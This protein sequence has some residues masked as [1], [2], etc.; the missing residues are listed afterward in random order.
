MEIKE[1]KFVVYTALFGDYDELVDPKEKYEGCDFICFTDQKHL[2][3]NI[4]K[5]KIVES[6]ILPPNLM[7]RMYK[8]LPHKYLSNYESSLYIDANVI[9]LDNPLKV[10]ER[11]KEWLIVVPRH[12]DRNCIYDEAIACIECNKT[13]IKDTLEQVRF[14]KKAG[15][16]THYGLSENNIIFRMHNH[17]KVVMLMEDVWKEL[18]RWKTY[19][20]QLCFSYVIWKNNFADIIFMEYNARDRVFFDMKPH[21]RKGSLFRRLKRK[22]NHM[23][24]VL[25]DKNVYII[26]DRLNI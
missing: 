10:L 14:Y 4:W 6:N 7:N 13:K 9:L 15:F 2:S 3:S 17:P 25:I 11:Y 8:W 20:D 22:I 24:K 19:R 18:I 16:P 21:K 26:R 12:P 1:N 23:R 5:V